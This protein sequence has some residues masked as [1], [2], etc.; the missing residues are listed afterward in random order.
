MQPREGGDGLGPMA[1]TEARRAF[2]PRHEK[3]RPL[4]QPWWVGDHEDYFGESG[5]QS[6]ADEVFTS[7]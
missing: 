4:G 5:G 3:S 2:E 6:A 7:C 1:C